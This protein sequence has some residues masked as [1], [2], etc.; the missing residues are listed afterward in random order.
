M[1][2]TVPDRPYG[3]RDSSDV[4]QICALAACCRMQLVLPAAQPGPCRMQ[5]MCMATSATTHIAG[6]ASVQASAQQDTVA[7]QACPELPQIVWLTI[8][9]LTFKLNVQAWSSCTHAASR[10]IWA[11]MH[12]KDSPPHA[13]LTCPV[14]RLTATTVHTRQRSRPFS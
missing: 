12:A 6:I 7:Q 3:A 13:N 5:T 10:P 4:R 2:C 8:V 14:Q 1:P 11:C 9:W